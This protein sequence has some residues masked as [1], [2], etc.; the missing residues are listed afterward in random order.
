MIDNETDEL[1]T[2]DQTSFGLESPLFDQPKRRGFVE[3]MSPEEKARQKKKKII[4]GLIAGGVAVFV[5]LVVIAAMFKPRGLQTTTP[6]ASAEP[7][8]NQEL[9]PLEQKVETLRQ[10]LRAADPTREDIPF[11][12]VDLEIELDPIKEK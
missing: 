11:P 5:L 6:E 2:G 10:E 1:V 7:Q 3:E 8:T 12:P 9:S 4:I